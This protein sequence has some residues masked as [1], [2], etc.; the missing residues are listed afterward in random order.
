MPAA[1]ALGVIM[2]VEPTASVASKPPLA[3]VKVTVPTV[4]LF[5][6]P[7]AVNAVE[8]VTGVVWV[9]P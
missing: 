2:E 6:K 4:S 9:V 7:L 1:A 8:P 5:C 3:Y